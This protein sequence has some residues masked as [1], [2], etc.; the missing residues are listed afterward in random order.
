[1]KAGILEVADIFVINKADREGADRVAA[2]LLAMLSHGS[3]RQVPILK[4]IATEGVGV[5]ELLQAIQSQQNEPLLK[6]RRA[7]QRALPVGSEIALDHIGIAVRSI[8]AASSFYQLLGLRIAEIETIAQE[9]V[10]V[11]MLPL[12][13]T[14]IEL[15]E[16]TIEQS[17]VGRF[18]QKRGE[19]LHHIALRVP[20]IAATLQQ[21]KATGLR[22]VKDEVQTG[23][24]GHRYFFVHPSSTGGVLV[25]IV[26]HAA[27]ESPR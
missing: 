22:L 24:G 7:I 14:R 1:M 5:T 15:I 19:G 20:Q 18:L 4:T 12:G 11:A 23:A 10:R 17:S 27:E 26:G 6:S 21:L 16:P 13:A 9:E 2:E 8:E 25:E 3:G